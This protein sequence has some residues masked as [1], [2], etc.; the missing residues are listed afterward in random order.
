MSGIS[1]PP[2]ATRNFDPC[3]ELLTHLYVIVNMKY[4]WS[5]RAADALL[6][7]LGGIGDQPRHAED[8]GA[9]E[10]HRVVEHRPRVDQP[11]QVG[12]SDAHLLAAAR[13]YD[14]VELPDA[15]G[16]PAAPQP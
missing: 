16:L 14:D 6:G 1:S 10:V 13:A 11:V 5:S 8:H 12:D 15:G 7:P 4:C 2:L 3:C 9:A